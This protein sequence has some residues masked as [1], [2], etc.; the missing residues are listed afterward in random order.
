[1]SKL[2]KKLSKEAFESLPTVPTTQRKVKLF[3]S[4]ISNPKKDKRKKQRATMRL[5]ADSS[6]GY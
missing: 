4:P 6:L 1:M 5:T 3:L 2:H